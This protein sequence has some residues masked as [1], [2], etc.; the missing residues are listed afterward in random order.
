M[1][2][3]EPLQQRRAAAAARRTPARRP[4]DGALGVAL[5]QLSEAVRLAPDSAAARASLQRA[6]T[7][8]QGVP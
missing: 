1:R 7:Q 3:Q 6:P 4:L 5:S 8:R 2:K